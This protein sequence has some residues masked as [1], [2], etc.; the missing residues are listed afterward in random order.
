MLYLSHRVG[1]FIQYFVQSFQYIFLFRYKNELDILLNFQAFMAHFF[2][3][4]LFFFC[5]ARYVIFSG[6]NLSSFFPFKG[7]FCIF[8]FPT[9]FLISS[10]LLIGNQYF[11]LIP[12]H[13]YQIYLKLPKSSSNV[14]ILLFNALMT[15]QL[16]FTSYSNDDEDYEG[17]DFSLF[18]ELSEVRIVYLNRF[19]QEVF[20]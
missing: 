12:P 8:H 10:R 19:V 16:E 20:Y 2:I 14:V 6:L 3:A 18:G 7:S 15:L 9:T 1:L 5:L 13:F 4:F 17:Y 11:I